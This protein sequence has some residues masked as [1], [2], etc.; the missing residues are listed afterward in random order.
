MAETF[1]TIRTAV[2]D[3]RTNLQGADPDAAIARDR[4]AAVRGNLNVIE[5]HADAPAKA[6]VVRDLRTLSVLIQSRVKLLQTKQDIE[7]VAAARAARAETMNELQQLRNALLDRGYA[8]ESVIPLIG[9]PIADLT[10]MAGRYAAENPGTAAAVAVGGFFGLNYLWGKIAGAGRSVGRGAVGIGKKLLIGAGITA[11]ALFG[12]EIFR[13]GTIASIRNWF[14]PARGPGTGPG[15][16]GAPPEESTK[17]TEELAKALG[18]GAAIGLDDPRLINANPNNAPN[19]LALGDRD[20]NVGAQTM[21]LKR[22]GDSWLF[23]V[24]GNRFRARFTMEMANPLGGM[25]RAAFDLGEVLSHAQAVDIGGKRYLRTTAA[26]TQLRGTTQPNGAGVGDT[27]ATVSLRALQ[28]AGPQPAFMES[29][30]LERILGL[31]AVGPGPHT[32]N[33]AQFEPRLPTDAGAPDLVFPGPPLQNLRR[34]THA[35]TFTRVP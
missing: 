14:T 25:S 35:I 4:I 27:L 29:T 20:I 15:P 3:I 34:K 7:V 18:P 11:A 17:N 19:I 28:L 23:E 26:F 24:K 22:V 30:E 12:V 13:P 5:A 16:G 2:T 33:G 1:D 8:E 31:L 21:R 32:I 9:Q 6:L 10:T